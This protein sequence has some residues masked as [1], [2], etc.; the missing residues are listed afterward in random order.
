MT[1][2][3]LIVTI[4]VLLSLVL[5]PVAKWLSFKF[6]IFDQPGHRKIHAKPIPLMGGAAIYLAFIL[7][8]W[9]SGI[10]TRLLLGIGAI[11]L[12][13]ILFGLFDDA[14]IKIRAR[15]KIWSHLVASF[16][17]IL[18]TGIS[19]NL[20]KFDPINW[21]LTACFITFMTNSMNMLDGMDGLVS[22]VSF[23]AALSFFILSI[24]SDQIPTALISLAVAGAT[25]GFLRYN[26][27]PASIFLGEAGSTF[28]G[29]IM[30]AISLNLEIFRLWNIALLLNLP[31]LQ[32]VSFIVPLIILGIPIFDTFFV[33]INRFLHHI[34]MSTPGKD[35]SH[36]RIHLMG[37][38]QRAT[39]IAS[40]GVQVILGAI[41]LA[42]V[43]SDLQQF[44]SLLLI[45]FVMGA[46][47]W[48]FL[49][50]VE[51]YA[52]RSAVE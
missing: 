41:A 40:Y 52:K 16:A 25:L 3:L 5:T 7:S 33:F 44:L 46:A 29:F 11:G 31:R 20:F 2:Y 28:L 1:T 23:L 51:V 21:V 4:A 13:F 48:T 42:M 32:F 12:F 50:R 8:L 30:A 35:H 43:N 27:N 47:T 49:S 19:F 14:G 36:H 17:F 22:G 39:V 45:V 18:I 26:F 10:E 34:K 38:S 9:F 37:L 15:Y 6:N 24:N